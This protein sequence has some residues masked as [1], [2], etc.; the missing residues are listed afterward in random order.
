MTA[1]VITLLPWRKSVNKYIYVVLL[2]KVLCEF[3]AARSPTRAHAHS[4]S[5][6]LV[7][8]AL[9]VLTLRS[10][11]GVECLAE[12]HALRRGL[13]EVGIEPPAL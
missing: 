7:H 4:E 10:N 3:L 9:L 11:L 5:S 1:L 13:Q 2:S 12:G 8:K 6:D